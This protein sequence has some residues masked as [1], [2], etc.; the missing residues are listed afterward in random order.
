MSRSAVVVVVLVIWVVSGWVTAAWVARRGHFLPAWLALGTVCGPFTLGVWR[1]S[2]DR[3]SLALP[4]VI[5][6]GQPGQGPLDV[7]VGIDGS[8]SSTSALATVVELLG[9]RIGRLTL[10]TV[11]DYDTALDTQDTAAQADRKKA[12]VLLEDVAET[13]PPWSVVEPALVVLA[14]CPHEALREFAFSNGYGLIVIGRR[15]HGVT[16]ALLGSTASALA[17]GCELPVL[18]VTA[19]TGAGGS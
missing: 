17:D 2:L 10:A 14:G 8:D 9:G 3:D 5:G 12:V 15:G 18:I 16:K 13:L 6:I 4:R 1:S 7:L 19:P 11:L